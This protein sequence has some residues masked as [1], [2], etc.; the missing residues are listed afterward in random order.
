MKYFFIILIILLLVAI[1]IWRIKAKLNKI[2]VYVIKIN[3]ADKNID[4]LLEK[5]IETLTK[6]KDKLKEKT[7]DEIMIDLPK[8]KNL[9]LDSFELDAETEKLEKELKETLEY[10]KKLVLDD[11][12]NA[13]IS[14]LKKADVDLKATKNYYNDNCEIYNEIIS[15]FPT[16]ILSKIKGYNLLDFYEIKEEEEFEILKK[17]KN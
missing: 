1:I 16:V 4:I 10:N 5:K 14:T 12:E 6:I 8:I 13:L 3:E 11:E 17:E 2:S 7:D 9:S 15:K